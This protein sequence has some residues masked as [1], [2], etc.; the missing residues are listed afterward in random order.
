MAC[1]K[2][3]GANLCQRY[4]Q[5][6]LKHGSSIVQRAEKRLV[7]MYLLLSILYGGPQEKEVLV[8]NMWDERAC[9]LH[10]QE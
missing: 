5:S 3:V 10:P 6:I 8:S 4:M 2:T 9:A 1:S 7:Y